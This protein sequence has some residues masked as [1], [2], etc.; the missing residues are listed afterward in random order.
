MPVPSRPVSLL[1]LLA[2]SSVPGN[3]RAD[4]QESAKPAAVAATGD[5]ETG[6]ASA[7]L[8]RHTGLWLRDTAGAAHHPLAWEEGGKATVLFFVL[9]DCPNANRLVPEIN[10]IAAD[11]KE[12]GARA[13]VVYSEPDLTPEK[14][15]AHHK[16]FGYTI[17]ALLDSE[18]VLATAAGARTS[19][20]AALILPPAVLAYRGRIDDRNSSPGVS[21][22]EPTKRDLRDALDKVLAGL[23]VAEP[24][25]AA[26]GCPLP[27]AGTL[28]SAPLPATVTWN[29]HIAPLVHQHCAS[30]HRPEEVGP[31]PLLTWED[32]RKRARQI[33]ETVGDRLMPPWHADA[34]S[35]PFINDRSLTPREIALFRAWH[36]QGAPRGDNAPAPPEP[37]FG[38]TLQI[39]NPDLSLAMEQPFEVPAEGRDIYRNFVLPLNLTEEKWARSMELRPSARGIVHHILVFVDTNGEA[40]KQDLA[41]PKPGFGGL[42]VPGMKYLVG[43]APGAGAL[44]LPP[45]LAWHFPK[46][47]NLVL[48]T[49]FHPNGKAEREATTVRLKYAAGPP[50]SLYHTIQLPPA[51]GL[52]S[53]LLIPAGQKE[54]TMR[55][56]FLLPVDADAFATGAHAHMLGK[57]MSLTATLPDGTERVLLKISDWDFAWQEQ[58]AYAT[59]IPLPKGTRLDS[60]VTWDNSPENPR[61]PTIPP[62]DVRW[63]QQTTDEMGSTVVAVIPRSK[64]D[65]AI[66]EKALE[67]H[68]ADK[69]VD[70]GTGAVQAKLPRRLQQGIEMLKSAAALLDGDRDG[71][72]SA[73]ERVPL[74]QML[75][76]TGIPKAIL[77][78]S[79]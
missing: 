68:I 17:P 57:R 66:L 6:R 78:S 64:D 19:P 1:L 37:V 14:A 47:S 44:T 45:D 54:H 5:T 12:R 2:L 65:S 70:I 60:V 72:L 75:H 16:E 55:D 8:L 11:Y 29:E 50:A 7:R 13:F 28:A 33:S 77:G 48:Q 22:P 76:G 30:C 61:N 9:S 46:G 62:V 15:A 20:E 27:D 42:T 32:T 21:R 23:P 18:Q 58:Y 74:V 59:R 3:A 26:V 69:I 39:T 71:A 67:D 31:F 63:G 4:L 24:I 35:P 25:T 49:H 10:R 73:T 56:T 41:D 52:L 79:P 34:A 40:L 43:W 51:F 38:D 53:G 36:E